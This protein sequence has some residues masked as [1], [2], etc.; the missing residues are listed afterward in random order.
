MKNLQS[1]KNNS[2]RFYNMF[3]PLWVLILF[4]M[5]WLVS[6]PFNFVV[7][8]IVLLI[9]LKLVSS[10]KIWK[11]YSRSILKVWICG[12]IADM[13]G[14]GLM[15]L[16]AMKAHDFKGTFAEFLV[17]VT[18]NVMMNPFK[19]VSS[20]IFVSVVVIL[21]AILIYIFNYKIC[22]KKTDLNQVQKKKISMLL[23]VLTAPYTFYLPTMNFYDILEKI[24]GYFS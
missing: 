17:P 5:F 2:V 13:I 24:A 18:E 1:N 4:P 6:M 11:N 21:T 22:L 20:F 10:S 14:G 9:G 8:S 19:T 16:L 12:Y 3:F 23:A 7:D 15:F